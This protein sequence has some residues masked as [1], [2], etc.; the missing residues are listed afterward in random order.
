METAELCFVFSWLFYE[1]P[2]FQGRIIAL[3]EG[4]TEHIVNMWADQEPGSKDQPNP[5]MPA[6][7]MVIGSVRLAVRV[8]NN[9][10]KY[11]HACNLLLER[12]MN[13]CKKAKSHP[14]KYLK[15]DI[16]NYPKKCDKCLCCVH[17]RTIAYR[18]STCLQRSMA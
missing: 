8:R 17:Y 12:S 6:A 9:A 3:E 18:K 13:L 10:V 7:P 16:C 4:P 5:P 1:K 14:E 11:R 2:G 15:Q